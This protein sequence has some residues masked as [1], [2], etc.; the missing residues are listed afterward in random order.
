[1]SDELFET[2]LTNLEKYKTKEVVIGFFGEQMLHPRF[3]E[4]VCM[5][6]KKRK[7]KLK[8]NT[9]M[10]LVTEDM[11]HQLGNIDEFRM[12]ME[13]I[14]AEEYE[15]L[16]PGGQFDVIVE[17][18]EYWLSLKHRPKTRIDYV[19]CS[20][21]KDEKSTFVDTWLHKMRKG[22][23]ILTKTVETYGGVVYD[24]HMSL[25]KCNV[26]KKNRITVAWNGDCT[27]C[28]LD[29]NIYHRIGNLLEEKDLRNILNNE[30]YKEVRRNIKQK[31]GICKNCFD[32][33]NNNEHE[34]HYR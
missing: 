4:Y 26:L 9:N 22:D 23:Y 33:S 29:V 3:V 21:N 14:N 31:K 15:K 16:R 12:S 25:H 1:M 24:E 6:P 17:K 10:S 18:M 19:T 13:S 28:N 27:P 11:M 2:I 32:A 5:F 34:F 30:K 7:Y 20:I 8:L